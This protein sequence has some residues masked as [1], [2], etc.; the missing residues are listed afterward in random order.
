MG[1]TSPFEGLRRQ[2]RTTASLR[3]TQDHRADAAVSGRG[4][5]LTHFVAADILSDEP[6]AEI[7]VLTVSGTV[8]QAFMTE[9]CDCILEEDGWAEDDPFDHQPTFHQLQVNG[10]RTGPF[11]M[12]VD[13]EDKADLWVQ[14][15]VDLHLVVDEDGEQVRAWPTLAGHPLTPA[16]YAGLCDLFVPSQH[17]YYVV[18]GWSADRLSDAFEMWCRQVLEHEVTCDYQPPA[19]PYQPLPE[20]E[21][22]AQC[23]HR[24][25]PDDPLPD[26]T[27]RRCVMPAAVTVQA[28]G[29][30]VDVCHPHRERY[31]PARGWTEVPLRQ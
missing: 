3:W 22:L 13:R 29:L 12:L 7:D 11:A 16:Q 15:D 17:S 4:P 23:E 2:L 20:R 18:D 10:P 31:S 8:A 19:R 27:L 14:A 28:P 30:Q 1:D 6:V 25:L 9:P 21:K 26:E 24:W 5:T